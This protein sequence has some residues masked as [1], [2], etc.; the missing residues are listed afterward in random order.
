MT[1]YLCVLEHDN[2]AYILQDHLSNLRVKQ[3]FVFTFQLINFGFKQILNSAIFIND[4]DNANLV[5]C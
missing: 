2:T 5:R 3:L 1:Q 4:T